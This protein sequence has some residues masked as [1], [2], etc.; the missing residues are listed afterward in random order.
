MRRRAVLE[1]K[2]LILCRTRGPRWIESV[3]RPLQ[4]PGVSITVRDIPI[5]ALQAALQVFDR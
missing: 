5:N 3:L 4:L 2:F 1:R